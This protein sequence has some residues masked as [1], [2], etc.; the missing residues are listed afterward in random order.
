MVLRR[1]AAALIRREEKR[2]GVTFDY[3]HQIARTD[4]G[5]LLRY[6]KIFGFLNPNRKVPALAYHTA[7]LRGAVAM[8]CGT[9]VEA[10]INLA[11]LA[12][13]S[14]EIVDHILGGHYAELEGPIA[15]TARLTDAVIGQR[16]DDSDARQAIIAA[17]GDAGLI[18]ISFA[19]NGAA[20]LPG[21][22]RAMGYAT[23]CDLDL[24][25]RVSG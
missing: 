18:E 16:T 25:R 19:M 15:A 5:L 1:L 10:E 14:P 22:K 2:I 8:D 13:L 6:N 12:G 17:Y 11:R 7:R 21:V 3:T 9:C 24:L 23:T 20:L 4:L